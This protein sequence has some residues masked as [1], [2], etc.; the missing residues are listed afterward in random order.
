M[1]RLN[2][3]LVA[4]GLAVGA[5]RV[6]PIATPATTFRSRALGRT[7]AASTGPTRR[8]TSRCL[9][10]PGRGPGAG[11]ERAS[12]RPV[13]DSVGPPPTAPGG[14]TSTPA[15]PA[16]NPAPT[17]GATSTPAAARRADG[18]PADPPRRLSRFR[19]PPTPLDP[20]ADRGARGRS[21]RP[22]ADKSCDFFRKP[23]PDGAERGRKRG[24]RR[25]RGQGAEKGSGAASLK[26]GAEKGSGAASLKYAPDPIYAIRSKRLQNPFPPSEFHRKIGL[27]AYV[28][29]RR[30]C[31]GATRPGRSRRRNPRGKA[32]DWKARGRD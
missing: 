32:Q 20:V 28:R 24:Q 12:L 3:V 30:P 10:R 13:I 2:A 9:R 11:T 4:A 16:V 25:K 29:P 23:P 7:A 21:S 19:F 15:A 1:T 17:G 8:A 31:D 5:R 18:P 26:S 6:R 22:S 27:R 14:A